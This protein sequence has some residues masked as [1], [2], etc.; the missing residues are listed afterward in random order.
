MSIQ[1][2]IH[3]MLYFYERRRKCKFF[4]NYFVIKIIIE[5]PLGSPGVFLEL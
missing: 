5:D 3:F 4:L 1:Y 2:Y